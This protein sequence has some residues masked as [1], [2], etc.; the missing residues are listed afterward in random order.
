[1]DK[2]RRNSKRVGTSSP[3]TGL[4]RVGSMV[5]HRQPT[6]SCKRW[7][8]SPCDQYVQKSLAASEKKNSI[9]PIQY[10]ISDCIKF[11]LDDLIITGSYTCKMTGLG[12]PLGSL[13]PQ[14]SFYT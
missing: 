4:A 1:M 13:L 12:I 10:R 14:A 9:T 8:S 3:E 7:P 11:S 2:T 5:F 6:Q